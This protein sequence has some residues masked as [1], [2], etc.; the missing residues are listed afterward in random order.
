MLAIVKHSAVYNAFGC[1]GIMLQIG[2]VRSDYAVC[3]VLVEAIQG[4]FSNSAT[5]LWLRTTAKFIYQKQRFLV[6]V[7]DEML[8]VQQ[9]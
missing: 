4:G 3:F 2:V 7:F 1:F 8:H 9:V 6:A 5:D